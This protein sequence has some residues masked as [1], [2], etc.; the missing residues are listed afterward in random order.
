MIKDELLNVLNTFNYPVF[1]Q[2]TIEPDAEIPDDF[3]TF[4]I[5]GSDTAAAFDNDDALTAWDINVNY[6]SRNP[7]NVSTVPVA[8]RAAMK[9][10][11]F[12]PQSRGFDLIADDPAFTGWAMDFFKLESYN[13]II[14]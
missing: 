7:A 2:G 1:L 11:G 14:N 6:Y 5:T 9:A 12:I 10:A 4:Q 3:L 8:I 13:N